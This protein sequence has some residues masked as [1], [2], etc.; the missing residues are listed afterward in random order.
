MSDAKIDRACITHAEKALGYRRTGNARLFNMHCT[1]L[2]QCAAVLRAR[3]K[4]KR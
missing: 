2:D 3:Q 4:Q 1:L